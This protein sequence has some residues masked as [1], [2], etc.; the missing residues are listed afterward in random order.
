MN[1]DHTRRVGIVRQWMEAEFLMSFE[2]AVS[3]C[4]ISI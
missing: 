3:G 4:L 1:W 2:E